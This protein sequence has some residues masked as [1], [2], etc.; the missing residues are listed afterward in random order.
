MSS[1]FVDGKLARHSDSTTPFG[2]YAA[3]L[4]DSA[5]W[6]WLTLTDTGGG[7]RVVQACV[8]LT[9]LPPI[10]GVTVSNL[11]H[12]QMVEPPRPR[13]IRPAVAVQIVIAVGNLQRRPTTR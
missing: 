8:V 12:G 11:A 13:W 7:S 1:D 3:P 9:W 5:F 2:R 4:A 6:T 10:A